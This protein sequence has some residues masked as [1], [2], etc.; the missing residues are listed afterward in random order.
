MFGVVTPTTNQRWTYIIPLLVA[1]LLLMAG[2]ASAQVTIEPNSPTWGSTIT[3]FADPS[4]G[5]HQTQRLYKSDAAFAELDTFHQGLIRRQWVPMHWDGSRF[6]ARL[7]VPEGCEAGAMTLY[8]HER[9]LETMTKRFVCRDAQGA[10]PPG[11]LIGGMDWGARDKANWKADI[12]ADLSRLTDRSWVYPSIWRLRREQEKEKFSREE[13]LREVQSLE[14]E[15]VAK[16]IPALF[17][18]VVYGYLVAKDPA[19]ALAKL[20]ELC[21]KFPESPYTVDVGIY[22]TASAV[23]G[24]QWKEYEEPL[25][26]LRAYVANTAPGNPALRTL[27]HSHVLNAPGVSLSALRTITARWTTEDPGA[28]QPYF[29]LGKRLAE[30]PDGA[31]EAEAL[32]T[33]A[34]DLS[35]LPRPFNFQVDSYRGRAYQLRSTFRAKKGDL[36]GALADTKMAA[37]FAAKGSVSE[38]LD[39]E[40]ELWQ[41]L[42]FPARAETSAIQ[43]YREGSLR[44]ENFMKDLYAARTG[45]EPGFSNY[46]IE[47]LRRQAGPDQAGRPAP[48]FAAKTLDGRSIDST[49]LRGKIVV[50]NFW[51]IGCPPCRVENPKLNQIVQELGDRVRFIGFADDA[52]DVLRTHLKANPF[53]YEIVPDGRPTAITFGVQAYPRHFIIDQKGNIVW[54]GAGGAAD[55]I[56]RLRA[57]IYRV[58]ARS[59]DSSDR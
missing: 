55:T 27:H 13:V 36:A 46:L 45:G 53:K 14:R 20:A 26:T 9:I 47:Q 57:M 23:V 34:I 59:A 18:S 2:S 10:L 4:Q 44:A 21:H 56:E 1:V 8:T 19:K 40:A 22:F 7:T 41:L 24:N 5:V 25:Q 54:E 39:R 50:V 51:F 30:L 16:P 33:K 28:M 38:A 35:F 49:S 58:L 15:A 43:A 3:V 12:D 32:L 6:V 29:V 31:A 42:G 17:S 48:A 52:A 11:E 37:V